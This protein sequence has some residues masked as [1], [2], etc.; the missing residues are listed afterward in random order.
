[1]TKFGV[2]AFAFVAV[3]GGTLITGFLSEL[4]TIINVI[5]YE[6]NHILPPDVQHGIDSWGRFA[7]LSPWNFAWWPVIINLHPIVLL[8][9]FSISCD[10]VGDCKNQN[11]N[12]YGTN[13]CRLRRSGSREE[14]YWRIGRSWKIGGKVR[15]KS[16][17]LDAGE[18]FRSCSTMEKYLPRTFAEHSI[19]LFI[20]KNHVPKNVHRSEDYR[21]WIEI[22]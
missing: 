7:I 5:K 2:H 4:R 1:M 22:P 3:I 10:L 15:S 19:G 13:R 17:H 18:N 9:M 8:E 6:E 12:C 11:P 20:W 21:M 16:L 14:H